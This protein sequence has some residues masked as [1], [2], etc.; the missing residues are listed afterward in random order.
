M[1]LIIVLSFSDTEE[2]AVVPLSPNLGHRSLK[3]M[4]ERWIWGRGGGKE[5]AGSRLCLVHTTLSSFTS[6]EGMGGWKG[7]RF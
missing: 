2:T 6:P 7:S 5:R 4:S 1:L 3:T